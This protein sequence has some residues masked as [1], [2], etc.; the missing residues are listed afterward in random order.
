MTLEFEVSAVVPATQ[1]AI[2][3]AWLDSESHSLMTGGEAS[4]SD[5]EGDSFEVWDGYIQGVNLELEPASRI[6]QRWRTVEFDDT[7]ED[8][9]LEIL[10]SQEGESTRVTIKH[11]KL[12]DHGMQYQQ[13]WIDSYFIPM[14]E[15]FGRGS[16]GS[17]N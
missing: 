5:K 10:L 14:T 15:Y 8:S 16:E 4:V 17:I 6:L 2:Y 11:S 3:D 1:A 9:L 7:D 12:P 13:G